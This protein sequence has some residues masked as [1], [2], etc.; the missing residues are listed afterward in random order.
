MEQNKAE[1]LPHLSSEIVSDARGPELDA[2]TVALEGWRRGLT[3]RWHTKQSENF[4][5][6]TT[7]YDEKPGK[8]FSL[9]SPQQTHYFFRTRGDKIANEAINI[10]EDQWQAREHLLRAGLPL[11][12]GK[13]FPADSRPEAMVK[14]ASEIGYPLVLKIL[15][16]EAYEE[17]VTFYISHEKSLVEM[18]NKMKTIPNLNGV[19][20][21]EFKLGQDYQLY[22]VGNKVVGA[23][24][25][26]PPNVTGDGVH[27]IKQLIEMKNEERSENPF[28]ISYPIHIDQENIEFLNKTGYTLDSVPE[29]GKNIY[30]S[31][32]CSI[33][34]GGDPVD[35]LDELPENIKE[36]AVK[37][38]QSVPNLAHGAV[39]IIADKYEDFSAAV[40][41]LSS[42]PEISSFLFPI[43]GK[44]RDIPAAII[45]YYF[46]ETIGIESDKERFYFGF[47]EVLEPLYSRAATVTTVS[48]APLGKIYA[49]KYIVTGDVQGIDYRRGL[50]KQAFERKLFGYVLNLSDGNIEIVV[51]GTDQEAVD[52]FKKA[53]KEDPERSDVHDISDEPFEGPVKVGFAHR[54]D[55]KTQVKTLNDI[56]EQIERLK[57]EL[58]AT[59]R[60]YRS[61]TRSL[62]WQITLPARKMADLVKYVM[63]II[64]K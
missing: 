28:L 18:F 59:E 9:S 54:V 60:E 38:I 34:A 3:L 2:Y 56:N 20:L 7:W 64:L 14:Y 17:S 36:L 24:N 33:T 29:Q 55:L 46:P 45:N 35:V 1:W 62:Y 40:I 10:A 21:E 43:E 16:S 23:I 39:D 22:V 12:D 11:P 44:S 51:A 47:S 53:I 32:K 8:L 49:K 42:T 61:Y 25:K 41:K 6:M 19:L 63:R 50:R 27:S 4:D 37:A 13:M 52:E 57:I 58:K 5:E 31:N 30:V 48:K 26:V 15:T